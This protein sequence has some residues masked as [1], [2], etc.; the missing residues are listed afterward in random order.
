ML[1]ASRR[2]GAPGGSTASAAWAQRPGTPGP[3]PAVPTAAPQAASPVASVIE[4]AV[5]VGAPAT[6]ETGRDTDGP[7]P[8]TPDTENTSVPPRVVVVPTS[9]RSPGRPVRATAL[10]VAAGVVLGAGAALLT[11]AL[12]P[13]EYTSEALA[14]VVSE[15]TTSDAS[16]PITSVF[17]EVGGSETVLRGA[18]DALGVDEVDLDEG[19]S[20]TQAASAPLVSIRM[21]T[22][23]ADQAAAWANAVA[24]ELIATSEEGQ[25]PGFALALVTPAVAPAESDPG[26]GLPAIAGAAVL[27]GVLVGGLTQYRTRRR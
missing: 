26:L 16:V 5:E 25:V 23:A 14:V 11:T 21:T 1:G 8:A 17:A 15:D 12:L 24:D 19:L 27:G 2:Q 6:D 10:G 13:A 4:P 3:Q 9:S 7:E 18:A 20:V 22:G